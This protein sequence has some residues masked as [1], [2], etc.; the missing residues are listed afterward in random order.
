MRI[1]PRINFWTPMIGKAHE[2]FDWC[3][4]IGIEVRDEAVHVHF[5]KTDPG[6][7]RCPNLISLYSRITKINCG[8]TFRK[9]YAPGNTWLYPTP[10]VQ[11]TLE[12]DILHQLMC[13][14]ARPFPWIACQRCHRMEKHVGS[15]LLTDLPCPRTTLPLVL[16]TRKQLSFPCG[17]AYFTFAD[18]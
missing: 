8:Q 3:F 18:G 14:A 17:A 6:W 5:V 4:T 10:M 16:R 13:S 15:L 12:F 11:N 7:R 1:D 9:K 2:N